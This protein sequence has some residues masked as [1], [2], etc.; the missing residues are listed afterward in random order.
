MRIFSAI[1][2]F[3]AFAAASAASAVAADSIEG[4][5]LILD[6]DNKP[7][8][9]IAFFEYGDARYG[10]MVAIFGDDGKISDT[11][12]RPVERAKGIDGN[13]YLCG[14]DII[15][16]LKP[17]GD[18]YAGTVVNPDS[19]CEYDCK[20]WRQSSDTLVVRG[21][22][23]IFG[24]NQYWRNF[25][26]KLLP[27]KIELSKLVPYSAKK[28]QSGTTALPTASGKAEN[29]PSA[30]GKLGAFNKM[31]RANKRK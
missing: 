15:Y 27:E 21:E 18:R 13:P 28:A 24:V 8:S 14:L 17:D 16:A 3:A 23:L 5:W 10:K 22:L 7:E 30:A 11:L 19:G 6:S 9:V 25:D 1:F 2:G 29:T 20:V 4:F 31:H 26:P 12:S